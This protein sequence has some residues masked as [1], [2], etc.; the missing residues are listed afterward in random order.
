MPEARSAALRGVVK[1]VA[2]RTLAAARADRLALALRPA[3]VLVLAY[4][5][6]VP[7]GEQARGDASLHLSQEDFARQLDA[8]RRTHRVVALADAFRPGD[9]DRPRAVIT[10]DDACR[11]ALTA[12][13]GELERRG[14]PATV[15]VAPGLLG[16]APWW[17]ELAGPE[18]LDPGV[19]AHALEVLGGRP[20]AVRA[21]A[22]SAGIPRRA[23]PAH[24]R[25]ATADELAAA[26]ARP[27]ITLAPHGWSHASL[28]SLSAHA[29]EDELARPLAWLYDRFG[30]VLPW[31]AY[32]YGHAA[33]AVERAAER[34]GY[35][36]AFRVDGGG[37]LLA[38]A[39]AHPFALPRLN[40]PA[41]VSDDGFRLRA[42]GVRRG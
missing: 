36:G 2:E 19:R 3:R 21:W 25:I 26:A 6:V 27:G 24:Q 7:A 10:F 14:L 4:H 8:L 28:P 15:F 31:L 20:A 1:R 34:A 12:G 32:P 18:G 38:D 30:T 13:I 17:D 23:V 40:V 37:F 35:A 29:L 9:G 42:A 16:S 11:G 5:N 33:A 39:A 41:G 22:E